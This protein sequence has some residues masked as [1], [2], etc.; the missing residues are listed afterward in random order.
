MEQK[1]LV[2]EVLSDV[3]S[4]TV[5]YGTASIVGLQEGYLGFFFDDPLY[6]KTL[7]ESIRTEFASFMQRLQSGDI[8]YTLPA[9]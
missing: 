3:L 4:G 2:K 5:A 1:K 7:P 8:S 6:Q 9:L